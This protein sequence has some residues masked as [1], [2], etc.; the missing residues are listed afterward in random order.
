MTTP[1]KFEVSFDR[2]HVA[3]MMQLV[4]SST[5]PDAPPFPEAT[6]EEGIELPWLKQV[7]DKW[8]REF[9]IDEFE[10]K[11]N[12]WPQYITRLE[13]EDVD[14]HFVHAKSARQDAIPLML[15]HG[16]PGTFHD[17]HKVIEP[18]VNPPEDSSPAFHV[19]VPSIPGYAWSSHP[20]RSEF[21]FVD[22]G[23]IYHRLMNGVLGYDKYA[24]QGGDWGHFIARAMFR[25]RI[26][27]AHIPVGHLNM[28]VG[29]P[30]SA[31]IL[32]GLAALVPS[33]LH[34]IPGYTALTT[35]LSNKA[36]SLVLSPTE[37]RGVARSL[38]MF[39][40]GIGYM[41]LQATKPLTIGY[42]LNDSPLGL[43]A[44]IGE[45]FYAWSDPDTLDTTD[46]IE[47]VALY[48]LTKSF[49]TSVFIYNRSNAVT[50]DVVYHPGR[51]PIDKRIALGF[52]SYPYEVTAAPKA[53][54]GGNSRLVQ[55]KEHS[56]GGHFAALDAEKAFV[57]DL[58][59]LAV[60]NWV[61]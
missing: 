61:G 2:Q 53:L 50:Q 44:Y 6:W 40:S 55:Y 13:D 42:A 59:E 3:R 4:E 15:L 25:D 48:Y 38:E 18:L 46:L 14:L 45:K 26:I 35:A 7:K 5:L 30:T 22:I 41:Q 19:V 20:R 16:W 23:R 33:F 27:A 34:A 17:F 36:Q 47:T 43:L 60:K 1:R 11:L 9:A 28:Y 29:V 32:Q 24:V 31:K 39:R 21:T 51:W 10:R 49:Y 56:K 52:G 8:I 58:R 37:R 57:D 12:R 54:L